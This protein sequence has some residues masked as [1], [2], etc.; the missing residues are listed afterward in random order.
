M[1]KQIN[2]DEDSYNRLKTYTN[3]YPHRSKKKVS[4]S[5]AINRL[6]DSDERK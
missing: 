1:R 6:I 4:F 5:E 3:T 2:V